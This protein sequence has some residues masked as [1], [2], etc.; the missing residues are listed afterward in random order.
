MKC[1]IALF[2]I[3][4]ICIP[5]LADIYIWTDD[6]GIKH[7]S[8]EPPVENVKE[9][10]IQKIKE[11][12]RNI[13]SEEISKSQR[14]KFE[15]EWEQERQLKKENDAKML[16]EAQEAADERAR[17]ERANKAPVTIIHNNEY[18][19]NVGYGN[20]YYE[21]DDTPYINNNPSPPPPRKKFYEKEE[22]K[23]RNIR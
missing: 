4:I 1:F 11:I 6:K 10:E 22:W 16:I 9:S 15:K 13:E 3:L 2:V 21:D 23:K 20:Y 17:E 12:E 5:A 18:N 8:N 19:Y 14:E 7:Y